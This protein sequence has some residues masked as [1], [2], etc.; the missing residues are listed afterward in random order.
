MLIVSSQSAIGTVQDV[1]K[2]NGGRHRA[3]RARSPSGHPAG[4]RSCSRQVSWLAGRCTH[5][6]FPGQLAQWLN[7]MNA[8]RL[9]LRGQPRHC[10]QPFVASAPNSHLSSQFSESGEPRTLHIVCSIK[11][12]STGAVRANLQNPDCIH[13]FVHF[14]LNVSSGKQAKSQGYIWSERRL[15]RLAKWLITYLSRRSA[16]R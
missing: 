10:W 14:G 12:T 1:S 6:A 11:I 7:R 16:C 5:S 13:K 3:R 4:G 15:A 9:Q 8:R 2:E